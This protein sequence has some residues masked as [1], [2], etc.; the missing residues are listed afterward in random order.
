MIKKAFKRL[1]YS[2]TIY[3][4][5]GPMAKSCNSSHYADLL[6]HTVMHSYG[7]LIEQLG[8]TKVY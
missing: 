5:C 6:K 3:L 2:H 1:L 4:G 8:F 7:T